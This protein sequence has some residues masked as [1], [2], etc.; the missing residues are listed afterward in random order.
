MVL[1]VD[2]I[3]TYRQSLTK[4]F[5]YI[6][7]FVIVRDVVSFMDFD[8]DQ[9]VPVRPLHKNIRS[10]Q[11]KYAMSSGTVKNRAARNM[12]AGRL[13][14]A[15]AVAF[16]RHA[17]VASGSGPSMLRV[18]G[19][20]FR[21]MGGKELNFTTSR[22]SHVNLQSQA[23]HQLLNG[24]SQGTDAQ[25]RVGR[26]I[27]IKSIEMK[28]HASTM[29]IT[30][31]ALVRFVIVLDKQPNGQVATWEQV[32]D[33]DTVLNANTPYALRNI[34]NKQRFWVLWD[35]GLIP[36]IGDASA[37]ESSNS[38]MIATREMYKKVNIPVQ[39]NQGTDATIGS[40]ATNALYLMGVS[41][42]QYQP[43]VFDGVSV[44]G[45]IRLRY[46]DS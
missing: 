13:G 10:H 46:A 17:R 6:S 35:S 19:Y 4:M 45:N 44:I 37:K 8:S 1:V 43:A 12:K 38:A 29:A 23:F 32:Y 3:I 42:A 26:R 15:D 25:Q 27:N 2:H 16:A 5:V 33:V 36:I 39:Y 40:I 22:I 24:I 21:S 30:K 7:T 14:R 9:V 18:G 11:D 28:V 31:M 41:T 20:S 34:S